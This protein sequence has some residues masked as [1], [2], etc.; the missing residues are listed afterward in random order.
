[1]SFFH[2]IRDENGREYEAPPQSPRGRGEAIVPSPSTG[3]DRVGAIMRAG[4]AKTQQ[5][6]K[7][8][9]KMTNQPIRPRMVWIGSRSS[10]GIPY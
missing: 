2:P 5:Q 3:R 10:K 7:I 4:K 9:Q 1:M 8:M 6:P